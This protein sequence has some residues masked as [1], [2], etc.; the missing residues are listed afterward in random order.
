[1]RNKTKHNS[2][3]SKMETKTDSPQIN[4]YIFEENI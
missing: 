4:A 3:L 1:M 2:D